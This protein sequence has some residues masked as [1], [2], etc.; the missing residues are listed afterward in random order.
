MP[1][2]AERYELGELIG[3]GGMA[4]VHRAHD[5]LLDRA[6][7][8]KLFW[9]P[10]DQAAHQRFDDEAV[11]LAR[12][13]HPG[14][15]SIYDVGRLG[16][17]PFLVMEFI[18]GL[19][20]QSWLLTGPLP[21]DHVISIGAILAE[22]LTHA[23]ERG[24]VHRDVKPSNIMLDQDGM[25]HLTDF[26]IARLAGAARI[27]NAKEIIGTPAYLAP[28]QLSGATA[29]P[30][31][32][33]YALALVLLECLTGR[34]EYSAAG[35][36]GVALSRLNQPPHIPADLPPAFADLLAAMTSAE[37][38]ERP[39]AAECAALLLPEQSDDPLA[40]LWSTK[41]TTVPA[42]ITRSRRRAL[43]A[44]VVGIAAVIV[45]LILLLNAQQPPART[46]QRGTDHAQGG[47]LTT[48][49]Q[50]T[51]PAAANHPQGALVAN[52]HSVVATTTT[53]AP[54]ASPTSSDTPPITTTT[55]QASTTA[56][57][58]TTSIP[59]TTSSGSSAPPTP[60]TATS[61]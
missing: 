8:V 39:S 46:Q 57:P 42:P 20:L 21:L 47:L 28:E 58:T 27:T 50:P 53:T 35:D 14:L 23:H 44:S 17:R 26:G 7:A 48:Q 30:A 31:V 34:L 40:P 54:S 24:V 22:A 15:V 43:A 11:A 38:A 36:L 12:L 37:P 52:E 55:E 9:A 49:P 5:R 32:D 51:S 41:D 45:T 13:S 1:E 6:V 25:P 4:E 18:D 3:R 33:V 10:E 2:L 61:G 16:D 19:S 29:S 56:P 59:P 60:P